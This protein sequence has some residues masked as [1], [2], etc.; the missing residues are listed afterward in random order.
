VPQEFGGKVEERKKLKNK[1]IVEIDDQCCFKNN[2]MIRISAIELL[3]IIYCVRFEVF[4]AV[5]MKN[6]VF[7]DVAATCSR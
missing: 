1:K 2:T 3:N 7:W 4:T 6:A 5:T